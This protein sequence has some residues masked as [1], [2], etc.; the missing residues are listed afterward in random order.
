[1]IES[2]RPDL[3]M[4]DVQMPEIDGFGVVKRLR[5]EH[6]PLVA[7]VTAYEVHALAAFDLG[8]IDYLLK[9]MEPRHVR[10][11][12]MRAHERLDT[13]ALRSSDTDRIHAATV[14]SSGT[15]KPV[16]YLRRIP[17][18][19]R[20]DIVLVP[21]SDIASIVS[22]GELLHLTTKS[23]E[24]HTI[25]HRLK[26]LEVRLDPATFLRLSR[27][28]IVNIELVKMVRPMPGATYVVTLSNNQRVPV[29]RIRA[30][31]LRERLVR[32]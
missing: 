18:R 12:L 6:L 15:G 7:F 10:R 26:D 23:G 1:M 19:K 13:A 11:T 16:D 28:A 2:L 17:V 9:P 25:S 29:S 21:V 31:A 24:R 32:L 5:K 3:A 20:D 8:A 27:G 30:R 4:L 14:E 22:D